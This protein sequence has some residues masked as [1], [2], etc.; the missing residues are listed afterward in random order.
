MTVV[1][2]IQLGNSNVLSSIFPLDLRLVMWDKRKKN[3][4]NVDILELK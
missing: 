1:G 2:N 4:I 3:C